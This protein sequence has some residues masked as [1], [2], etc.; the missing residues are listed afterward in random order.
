MVNRGAVL[1]GIASRLW[2]EGRHRGSC[3]LLIN[4]CCVPVQSGSQCTMIKTPSKAP[5]V[6]LTISVT[7]ATHAAFLRLSKASSA[8]IGRTMGEWLADTSEAAEFTALKMEQARAA[9]GIVMREMHAYALGLADET[10]AMMDRM[11]A[12]GAADRASVTANAGAR[13]R[14][15]VSPPLNPPSCNTGGKLPPAQKQKNKGGAL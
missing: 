4:G 14:A 8:S 12:K 7:P 9:P 1:E 6:R 2:S 15:A 11:K 10:G 13:D 3:A 5:N